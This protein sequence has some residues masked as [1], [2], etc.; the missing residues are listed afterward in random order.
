MVTPWFDSHCHLYELADDQGVAGRVERARRADVGGM[1]VVGVDAA[2]SRAAV[3]LAQSWRGIWAGAAIHPSETRGWDESWMD[4][5]EALLE[6]PRARAV[7]ETGLDFYWDRSFVEK[8]LQAFQAH[9]VLAKRY[10]LALVVH[11]R[12]SIDAALEMLEGQGPPERLVFHCWSGDDS[13]LARALGLGAYVSFAGN[14]SF[15]NAER[16]R[17]LAKSTP[18]DRLLVETD[19]PY[20]APVPHRGKPNEPANVRF[21]GAAVA[22]ARAVTV[23]EIAETTTR[24]ALDLLGLDAVELFALAR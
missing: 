9:I 24:N 18:G 12:N 10:G 17:A 20:L 22:E 23:P 14:V 5:I 11:T 16:L 7:G 8:Q 6:H 1:L 2:S 15:K 3:E 13:Q 21:V 4:E 19:S